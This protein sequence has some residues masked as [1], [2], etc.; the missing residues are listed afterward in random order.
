MRPQAKALAVVL[1]LLGTA[2]GFTAVSSLSLMLNS[3]CA[4]G[5][6][7][8]YVCSHAPTK[9]VQGPDLGRYERR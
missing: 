6:W 4:A 7:C 2:E 8:L 9:S 5:A 3:R 1:G